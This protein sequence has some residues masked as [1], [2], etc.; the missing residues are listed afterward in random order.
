MSERPLALRDAPLAFA[1]QNELGVVYLFAHVAKK[2]QLRVET[3]QPSFPDCLAYRRIGNSE[4]LVRIEFELR[5]SNFRAH[6]HNVRGCDCIVCWEHDWVDVPAHI[7]VIEL[8]REFGGSFNVWIQPVI[9]QQY[10]FLE[11]SDEVEWGLSKRASPGD[12]LLMYRSFFPRVEFAFR[13]NFRWRVSQ[14]S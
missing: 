13:L 6:G 1:P 12:L 14:A 10:R 3:V 11:E 4:R 2:F 8:K 7:E 9:K 5:S